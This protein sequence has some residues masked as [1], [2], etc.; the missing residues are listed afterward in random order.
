MWSTNPDADV[1]QGILLKIE[2]QQKHSAGFY[3]S[4]IIGLEEAM[5]STCVLSWTDYRQVECYVLS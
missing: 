4:P 2:D 1:L 3:F 5:S